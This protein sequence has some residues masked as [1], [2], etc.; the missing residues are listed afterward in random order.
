MPIADDIEGIGTPVDTPAVPPPTT[1]TTGGYQYNLPP[2]TPGAGTPPQSAWETSLG[3]QGGMWLSHVVHG[4]AQTAAQPLKAVA[5]GATT[6]PVHTVLN[7][8][9]SVPDLVSG[10]VNWASRHLGGGNILPDP[11]A[12]YPQQQ[13]QDPTTAIRQPFVTP[14]DISRPI[15]QYINP[16]PPRNQLETVETGAAENVGGALASI[17]GGRT[18]ALA[19]AGSK[20][21]MAAE[22]LKA[23]PVRQ[24]VT[25]AAQGAV[26]GGATAA[27]YSPLEA[28]LAGIITGAG[29]GATPGATQ[30]WGR[31][32]ARINA[33]DT[34]VTKY[35]WKDLPP[36]A[37]TS[38]P[39]YRG[40][41]GL[42]LSGTTATDKRVFNN[43]NDSISAEIGV[44]HDNGKWDPTELSDARENAGDDIGNFYA[45]NPVKLIPD[46][47]AA[48]HPLFDTMAKWD[49]EVA[50]GTLDP[51]VAKRISAYNG[52]IE[53]RAASTGSG[54]I[55]GDWTKSQM[56]S[57]G[58][59]S[60]EAATNSDSTLRQYFGELKDAFRQEFQLQAPPDAVD[61]FNAANNRYRDISMVADVANKNDRQLPPPALAS[62]IDRSK[63]YNTKYRAPTNLDEIADLGR[64]FVSPA[65]T[66]AQKWAAG[67][68]HGGIGLGGGT[69]AAMI[70]ERLMENPP[71][72]WGQVATVAAPAIA[73]PF[74]GGAMHRAMGWPS[75]L[76]PTPRDYYARALMNL[77][78]SQASIYGGPAPA[79]Q[80][81]Q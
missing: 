15:T 4:A 62:A 28:T 48:P 69:A 53:S 39:F 71:T 50:S 77:P 52:N 25:S 19:P 23:Q 16:V 17:L 20:A 47:P 54:E 42:P 9:R 31:D 49:S 74:V 26:T 13:W 3:H 30:G 2:A 5:A 7:W 57:K 27:G 66:P 56:L 55:P 40:T 32:P 33:Y 11:S 78:P 59:I 64:T 8:G 21:A 46:D 45:G 73:A 61:A 37:A 76:P 60:R 72:S 44:P 75:A 14:Q 1:G 81:G 35:N 67:G 6:D 80:Q 10:P 58:T 22:V 41:S 70:A 24:L 79:W 36:A 29:A 38:T 68:V 51:A 43:Y 18:L 34:A 65:P 63:Y 12:V